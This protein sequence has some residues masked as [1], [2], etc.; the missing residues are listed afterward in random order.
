VKHLNT[1]T[2][3]E[4]PGGV[5]VDYSFAE[6]ADNLYYDD[7]LLRMAET[8]EIPGA[9][10]FWESASPFIVLG[11]SGDPA[12][13][14]HAAAVRDADVPVYR[15]SSGG[16]TVV[17]GPG[18]LNYALV[19]PKQGAW[20]DVRASYRDISHWLLAAL[21]AFGIQGAYEPISDLAVGGRKFSGNAQ[22]RGR[23]F[24][25]QH[26][27]LLYGFDLACISSW[28]AQPQAQPPYRA[29]R[30]HADFV[31]NVDLDV[32]DFKLLLATRFGGIM[33]GKLLPGSL[34]ALA[35]Q[36]EQ[37]RVEKLTVSG[38]P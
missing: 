23:H 3:W 14:L 37:G 6:P 13:D 36:R 30:K 20:Q 31:T 7:A 10:R 29:N 15:R 8:G 11:R 28:L 5:V 2:F 21:A 34:A 17:Q 9:L 35:E 33:H 19:L 25:L 27:T 1:D 18:C 22:R 38:K 12:Q 26:G 24:L 4:V 16:G 32:A